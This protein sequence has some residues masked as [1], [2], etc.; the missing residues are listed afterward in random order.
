MAHCQTRRMARIPSQ[1]ALPNHLPQR[2]GCL[3]R[4]R[5]P[6]QICVDALAS[7]GGGAPEGDGGGRP[8]SRSLKISDLESISALTGAF[9]LR[10]CGSPPPC[11]GG[12]KDYQRNAAA[13]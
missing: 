10:P 6:L 9:P 3:P 4:R 2:I 11:D 1:T 12:G 8:H 5:Q 13:M 7:Y